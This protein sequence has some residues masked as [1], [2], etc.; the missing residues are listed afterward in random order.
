M[1][2]HNVLLNNKISFLLLEDNNANNIIYCNTFADYLFNVAVFKTKTKEVIL[3]YTVVDNDKYVTVDVT[4]ENGD[5]YPDVQ[6]KIVVNENI[7]TPHSTVNLID[8]KTPHKVTIKQDAVL[9]EQDELH[10]EHVQPA[11]ATEDTVQIEP[12]DN[13]KI[14]NRALQQE[15][16]L[17]QERQQLEKQ[18]I[19]LDKQNIINN[20]L[21][22]YKQELLQEYV[23]AVDRQKNILQS[24]IK[25]TLTL[26]EHELNERITNTFGDYDVQLEDHKNK[27]RKEQLDF[28]LDKID[29]SIV[30]TQQDLNDL[31]DG[32]FVLQQEHLHEALHSKSQSL[33]KQYEQKLIVELEQH[34]E[35]LF[36]EFRIVSD[37]RIT[38]LLSSKKQLTEQQIVNAFADR[39]KLFTATFNEKLKTTSA[40]LSHVVQE[41][42]DQ[43]PGITN[44]IVALENRVKKL[45]EEK[46][47]Q[48]QSG[49][50]NDTQQ[51]YIVDT[52]QYWA[53]RILELGGGGG[54]VAAQYANGGTMNGDL[55]V[56]S[57]YLSGGVNLLDIFVTSDSDNQTLTYNN[58]NYDLSISS[59]NTVNLSSINTTFYTNSGKYE[60]AYT[61]VSDNS[62]YW[63]EAYSNL[64]SNSAAY[65]SAVDISLLAA[66]SG[67]WNSN[68]TTVNENSAYWSEAYSN[69]TSNSAAYLSAVDISLLA[70]ASGSWN[71]NYTTVNENSAYWADT[72]YDVTFGQNVTINGNLTAL[73]T[74]IFKNTIFT[75]TSALSVINTG[76]GPALYVYQAAGASDVA[77]FYDGDGVEVLHV[78]NANM[79]QGGKVGINESFPA[80]ELTVSGAISANK[81]ITVSGGNSNQ[82]NSNYTTTN[83]NSANWS[84]VY[85]SVADNSAKY[86][87]NWTTTNN[88]SATW[89]SVYSSYNS[90][91]GRYTTLDYLS[92]NFIYLSGVYVGPN[93]IGVSTAT[94][95]SA[96]SG[97]YVDPVS[98]Y[99]GFYTN[100]PVAPVDVRGNMKAIATVAA[101]SAPSNIKIQGNYAYVTNHGDAS[102]ISYDLTQTTVVSAT[103]ATTGAANPQGLYI[104]GNYAYVATANTSSSVFQ[105]FDISNPSSF[106]LL[107]TSTIGVGQDAFDV[108]VQGNYAFILTNSSFTAGYIVC[109]DISNPY[110]PIK[111]FATQVANNGGS[112]GLTIQGRYLYWASGSSG[113]ARINR[114]DVSNPRTIPAGE[115]VQIG[116]GGFNGV[117]VRGKYVYSYFNGNFTVY[118]GIGSV[119]VSIPN[120]FGV[121]NYCSIILQGN[122][123]YVLNVSFLNKVDISTP[124]SPRLIQSISISSGGNATPCNFAIQGR[125]AYLADRNN[126]KINIVDLGGAYVQ[127]L[128]AGGIK[129][130]S[131]DVIR[132]TAIGNDLDVAGGAAFGRGF[133]SYKDSNIQGALTLTTLS[134]ASAVNYFSVLTGFNSTLFIIASTGNIGVGTGSPNERLTV[135]GTISTNAHKTSQDW[136][137]NWTTTNS[138]SATWSAAYSNLVSNSANYL[139][140]ASISYVNTNF[141]KISG[142]TMTGALS[143]MGLSADNIYSKGIIRGT[144]G[145]TIAGA[146]SGNNLTTSFGQGSATGS[147]SFAEGSGKALGNYSHAEGEGVTASGQSSHAEGAYNAASGNYSHAEGISNTTIGQAS[148][149][150]GVGNT[151]IGYASHAEGIS[152]VAS[153]DYSHAEGLANVMGRR[154]D[155]L[156]YTAATKTFT[157]ASNVSANFSYVS[158][159]TKIRGEEDDALDDVFTITVA[160]RNNSNGNIIATE[161]VIFFD[162]T[163]GYLIDNSGSYGHAEGISNTVMG[164]ASHAEGSGNTTI[165]Q[166]SHAEGASN[167]ASGDYSHAEGA[168][169]AALGQSSHAEGSNT[170]A[171][172]LGSHAAGRYAQAAHD[173][174][175]IWKGSTATNIISSTR[176]DQ[177]MVSAA[178]GVY[179]PG[180][181]GIGT[182]NNTNALTVVGTI[183]TNAH[184]TSNQWNSTYTTL[185]ANSGKYESAYTTLNAN[186]GKYESAYTSLNANSANYILSGGN[187]T[188]SPL[189]IGSNANY[190][191]FLKT[192]NLPRVVITQAGN[193][194]IGTGEVS[195]IVLDQSLIGYNFSVLKSSVASTA[196]A[197]LAFTSDITANKMQ[198]SSGI[199]AFASA[200]GWGSQTYT[201]GATNWQTAIQQAEYFTIPIYS[202][203]NKTI[204]INSLDS[205][206]VDRSPNGPAN[207]ALLYG[208]SIIPDFNN[209]TEITTG[210]FVLANQW[211]DTSLQINQA[212]SSN[213]ITILPETS[214]FIFLVPYGAGT[215]TGNLR[216][217]SNYPSGSA[218]DLSFR[219]SIS[220]EPFN[221]LTV[222][223]TLS[224]NTIDISGLKAQSTIPIVGSK[225]LTSLFLSIMV[226]TSS[227]YIPLY[228]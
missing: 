149:A 14:F 163:L 175:W 131:L 94:P 76:P 24:E 32:K 193:V 109:Y 3:E 197:S 204:T 56:T 133:K 222:N 207:F 38:Q 124:M 150:E 116:G 15:R 142:D 167:V 118:N 2:L 182:D 52:A 105:I 30:Q 81:D 49:K 122:C 42:A 70:A 179:V 62:A 71:S 13:V 192:N 228:K 47:K 99:A 216:F 53:R 19:I 146:I 206:W 134:G 89:S 186:S 144:G 209:V 1:S 21:V 7:E 86:D 84:S 104:N 103:S 210:V 73:G 162:S 96:M 165:G 195:N 127:Q 100:A 128:Q 223:G 174:T 16:M 102:L 31:I 187:I 152:N 26:A 225:T 136:S 224:A 203:T 114:M 87:S 45:L 183:S 4:L 83:T 41:F 170:T 60:S 135:V 177:F 129:T 72:R 180:N 90:I 141:V 46:T 40:E 33:E 171:R 123:A 44:N 64:T 17:A 208:T 140:G 110:A 8:L 173:R 164:Q 160:S 213:P 154:N 59:G 227:L 111:I 132:N 138:N 54:S 23:D 92:S 202:Q 198:R 27:S 212:L 35:A 93:R 126:S 12:P 196:S 158:P 20:K 91:S 34:K 226:G 9:K 29:I 82:W 119:S 98:G 211:T 221:K 112:T 169:N 55:N 157:F 168:Y 151:I 68:Y 67:S 107:S 37:D 48:E 185:N 181:M 194:G 143:T 66:A 75:T 172:G 25:E 155:F 6:F 130:D 156:T 176:T 184:G 161:D 36:E 121:T 218:N 80:A 215:N 69:L 117:A 57:N 219:G 115:A 5:C 101:A 61:T 166:A 74:S 200:L 108:V 190:N 199:G 28:I 214:G 22:E 50:F 120:T 51:K 217:Q 205:F 220:N 137:S 95:V 18:K 191:L 139:S 153:G 88:N 145:F 63:S 39:E 106:V 43:L 77:S 78:G 79:G 58:S 65:L 125:Y 147:Y 97:M 113:S 148:H 188:S 10:D 178:G 11:V 85:T 159:G 201:I 189:H